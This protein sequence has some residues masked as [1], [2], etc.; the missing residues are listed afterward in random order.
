MATR[1]NYDRL[2]SYYST[3]RLYLTGTVELNSDLNGI[4]YEIESIRD[5]ILTLDDEW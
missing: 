1:E 3:S 4:R 2:C 5:D